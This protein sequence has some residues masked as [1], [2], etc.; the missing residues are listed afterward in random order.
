MP[1]SISVQVCQRRE[2]HGV[3]FSRRGFLQA[4]GGAAAALLLG[5]ARRGNA[6]SRFVPGVGPDAPMLRADSLEKFVDPLPLPVRPK[7]A[8]VRN[9]PGP[10]TPLYRVE[11][12]QVLQR[13][14]RDLPPTSFWS[15]GPAFPG[16][17]FDVRRGEG[18]LVEW[19]NRLPAKHFLPIDHNIHGAEDGTPGSARCGPPSWRESRSRERRQSGTLAHTGPVGDATTIRTIRM[20]PRSGITITRWGL[21]G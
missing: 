15:F 7:P 5:V 6:G 12:R 8:G 20:P 1:V 17:T 14:H 13:V 19:T 4:S 18:V 9:T 11:L 21:I 3:S 16:P 10:G 2:D